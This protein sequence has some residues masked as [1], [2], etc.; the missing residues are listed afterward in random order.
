MNTREIAKELR[1]SHWAGLMRERKQ[2]GLSISA[3]CKQI[4]ISYKTYYYWQR[5]LRE[6][7]CQELLAHTQADP[8]S[9]DSLSVPIGWATCEISSK[10]EENILPIEINGC[11]VLASVDTDAEFLAKT[12]KVLMSLC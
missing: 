5:K 3:F 2:S 8:V 6:A 7:A 11:R 1:L 4:G 12:C 10:A 9:T